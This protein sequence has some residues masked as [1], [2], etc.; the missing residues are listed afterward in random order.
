MFQ[1]SDKSSNT[2][3]KSANDLTNSIQAPSNIPICF[4][5]NKQS[6]YCMRCRCNM[7][8]CKKHRKPENHNCK[9][10][11]TKAANNI[12]SN[13]LPNISNKKIDTI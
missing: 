11:Y 3:N 12:I 2:S 7:W 5:C 4:F 8:T 6:I 13:N 9:F 1:N 10:D